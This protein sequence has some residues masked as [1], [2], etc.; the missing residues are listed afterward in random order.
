M[1]KFNFFYLLVLAFIFSACDKEVLD[2]IVDENLFGQKAFVWVNNDSVK[3]NLFIYVPIPASMFYKYGGKLFNNGCE[4]TAYQGIKIC[5]NPEN[6]GNGNVTVFFGPEALGVD[7]QYANCEY[8]LAVKYK[9]SLNAVWVF[10]VKACVEYCD[11][12]GP[13]SLNY[14]EK[15]GAVTQV[16]YDR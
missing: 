14:G 11:K 8:S 1:N 10:N 4:E 13:I 7:R 5:R 12:H 16:R 9:G 6:N 3:E 2:Q 15:M